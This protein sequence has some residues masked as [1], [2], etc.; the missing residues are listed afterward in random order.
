[1]AKPKTR[2]N[3]TGTAYKR[4]GAKTW[5]AEVVIGTRLPSDPSKPPIRIKRT[6]GGFAKKADALD[7][8]KILLKTAEKPGR[9][10]LQQLYDTW[11]P[12]Y[13]PRVVPSTMGCYQAA[14]R[15][16]S[17]LHGT[18][19]DL[20]SAG[21]LQSC[22]DACPAG[23]RTHENMKALAGLL[24]AYAYDHDFVP[25]KITENLYTGKGE[26]TQREPITED[27]LTVIKNAIGTEP[28]AEYVFALCYLGFRPT[29]FLELK[30]TSLRIEKGQLI[31]TEGIKTEA[32]KN[33]QVPVP[34]VLGPIFAE[35]M[36]T[37][38]TDLLFPQYMYS[39]GFKRVFLGYKQ[40][41]HEYFNKHIF[42]PMMKRLGIAENKTPYC[43]RHTYSDKLKRADA[44]DKTKAAVMGHTDYK[45]TQSHYQSTDVES[46]KSLAVSLK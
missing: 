46:L 2:G 14:F 42:Q 10:T 22:M 16:F 44:D 36:S 9:P 31:L 32:G 35:R 29:E 3:G 45:F 17:P 38:G 27:E 37:P 6:K 15:H 30:K 12:W 28:F 40:M 20:I 7:Y 43:A 1:M 8:C 11:E 13:S 18:Y 4:P 26:T 33:R 23:K 41:S 25:K 21:D 19:I 39:R 34:P 24:W 5:T